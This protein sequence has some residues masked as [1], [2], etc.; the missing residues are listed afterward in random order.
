MKR[1]VLIPD[2]ALRPG[3]FAPVGDFFIFP[4]AAKPILEG[5][6]PEATFFFCLP[7]ACRLDPGFEKIRA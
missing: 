4:R 3:A 5:C 2:V 1:Q 7:L 6:R